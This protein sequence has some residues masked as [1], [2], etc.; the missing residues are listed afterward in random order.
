MSRWPSGSGWR[1]DRRL[2]ILRAEGMGLSSAFGSLRV[3]QILGVR[4][5]ARPTRVYRPGNAPG[6]R[7]VLEWARQVIQGEAIL[8][9]LS[10]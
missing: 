1:F 2:L 4:A 8:W 3:S 6:R 10:Q 9:E 7:T 5:D